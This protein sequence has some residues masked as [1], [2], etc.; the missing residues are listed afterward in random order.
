VNGGS[1]IN[2]LAWHWSID[3]M[4]PRYWNVLFIGI[5]VLSTWSFGRIADL[6]Q[7]NLLFGF[8][9]STRLSEF[10]S[11]L[12]H[13]KVYI[14]TMYLNSSAFGTTDY[15]VYKNYVSK[16]KCYL[17]LQIIMYIKT[18]SMYLN[19]S[20]ISSPFSPVWLDFDH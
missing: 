4:L 17:L 20:V 6:S 3:L 1:L 16:F 13:H 2:I 19:S 5:L 18:T 12:G 7:S 14:K 8:L 9:I 10:V 15:Y 11:S